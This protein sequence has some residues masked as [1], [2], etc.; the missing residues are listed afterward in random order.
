MALLI[1]RRPGWPEEHLNFDGATLIGR[2]P[3]CTVQLSDAAV[4]TR[5]CKIEPVDEFWQITD[6]QS[7]TGTWVDEQRITTRYLKDIDSIRIADFDLEF[8]SQ[9]DEEVAPTFA[10]LGEPRGLSPADG[11]PGKHAAATMV[12]AKP[13]RKVDAS[14]LQKVANERKPAIKLSVA[15]LAAVIGGYLIYSEFGTGTAKATPSVAHVITQQ[16]SGD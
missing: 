6:L 14:P 12:A 15:A 9:S 13:A 8:H 3:A 16:Q 4:S 7:R 1:I 11:V 10:H 5:H 2:G